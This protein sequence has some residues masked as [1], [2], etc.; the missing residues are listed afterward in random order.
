MENNCNEGTCGIL[1]CQHGWKS[2]AGLLCI[3]PEITLITFG[4]DKTQKCLW[5]RNTNRNYRNYLV[6]ARNH[7]NYLG[8]LS[9]DGT[10][11]SPD[12]DTEVFLAEKSI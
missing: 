5:K 8:Y 9:T 6:C 1:H 11:S 4:W 7:L 12:K 2:H 10:G 3:P